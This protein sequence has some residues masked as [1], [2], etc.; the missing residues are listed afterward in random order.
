MAKSMTFIVRSFVFM[1]LLVAPA[2]AVEIEA[3]SASRSP[4]ALAEKFRHSLRSV[5]SRV[6]TIRFEIEEF[7]RKSNWTASL[8]R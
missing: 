8:V 6:S 4:V 3:D 2:V 5:L 7:Q 1:F